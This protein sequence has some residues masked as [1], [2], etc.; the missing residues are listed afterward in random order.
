MPREDQKPQW[1]LDK[2]YEKQKIK[3]DQKP[4]RKA[5][6]STVYADKTD[7]QENTAAIKNEPSV[8]Q[9]RKTVAE[10][11]VAAS[12]NRYVRKKLTAKSVFAIVVLV[13]VFILFG[14]PL[15]Y[16][17][18]W[19]LNETIYHGEMKA[20]YSAEIQ[21]ASK[22]QKTYALSHRYFIKINSDKTVSCFEFVRDEDSLAITDIKEM[23]PN[24]LRDWKNVTAV[25]IEMSDVLGMCSDGTLLWGDLSSTPEKQAEIKDYSQRNAITKESDII[26]ISL[27]YDMAYALKSDGSVVCAGKE[28]GEECAN[29]TDIVALSGREGLKKDGTITYSGFYDFIS[30]SHWKNLASIACGDGFPAGIRKDGTV[31]LKDASS[32]EIDKARDWTDILSLNGTHEMMLGVKRDGTVAFASKEKNAEEEIAACVADWTDI[33]SVNVNSGVVVGK[34]KTGRFILAYKNDSAISRFSLI[35]NQQPSIL[36]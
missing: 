15:C 23:E 26:D 12:R 10:R 32:G 5:P 33:K 3:Y 27:K 18:Y 29:R 22:D 34:D 9:E 31:Q 13:L 16:S 6:V 17:A 20:D 11:N 25:Q 24:P 7:R 36:F 19:H 35:V 2:E 14:L 21:S 28:K 8:T 30:Y 4:E 1:L